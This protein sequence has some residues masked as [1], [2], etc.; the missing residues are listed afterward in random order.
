MENY[1]KIEE[2]Y[3]KYETIMR[4]LPDWKIEAYLYLDHRDKIWDEVISSTLNLRIALQSSYFLPEFD[5]SLVNGY[6]MIQIMANEGLTQYGLENKNK[7]GEIATIEFENFK[8]NNGKHILKYFLEE[9]NLKNLTESDFNSLK[10]FFPIEEKFLECKNVYEDKEKNLKDPE[11]NIFPY[12]EGERLMNYEFHGLPGVQSYPENDPKGMKVKLH[13]FDYDNIY[14]PFIIIEA[15]KNEIKNILRES[16]NI[17]RDE[18]N[19]PRVGEGWVRE[20]ELY[21]QIKESFPNEIIIHHGRP[22]WL[23]RQHLDIYFPKRNIGIEYQGDQHDSPIEFFG[24]QKALK[25]RKALDKRKKEQCEVNGCHLIY[26]YPDYD[27]D[28]LK[29]KI[30]DIL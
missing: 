14:V 22:S 6:K 17:F 3:G 15:L 12:L 1:R 25:N 30:K 4:Y 23:G 16:E 19:M 5:D 26:V 8:K 29:E 20:S 10:K 2:G 18:K 9:F 13:N 21:Y 24:G 27:F 28:E 11:D 7:I